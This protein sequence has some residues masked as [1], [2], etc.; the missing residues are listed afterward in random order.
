[1]PGAE[2]G[3]PPGVEIAVLDA[4]AAT[5]RAGE[6]AAILQD[7]VAGGASVGFMASLGQDEA[8]AYWRRV[9]EGVAGGS[10]VL[11]AA[12][13]EGRAVGT[14]QLHLAAM[15]NQPH[16]ADLAKL[17]VH[18]AARGRG[19]GSTLLAA[20]ERAALARGRDLLTLDTI[21]GSTADHL[22]QRLGWTR[23]GVIPD[24][25]RMPDG[26]LAGTAIFYKRLW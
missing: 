12:F 4:A 8:T 11:L 5:A 20:A 1:M 24:Y 10:V 6:L 25:A 3:A 15:P 18:R 2:G 16:R 22:Y 7:A 14:V 9:A 23:V 13:A 26:P 21:T 17:L 19:I